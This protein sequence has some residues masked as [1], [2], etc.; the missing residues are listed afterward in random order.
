M[1]AHRIIALGILA[2]VVIGGLVNST[3]LFAADT[4]STPQPCL[5]YHFHKGDSL[6]Y[7]VFS[8]DTVVVYGKPTFVRERTEHISIV[9]DYVDELGNMYLRQKLEKVLS[10]ESAGKDSAI[11]TTSH[12]VGRTAMIIM[13]STGKRSLSRQYDTTRHAMSVGGPFQP[14]LLPP[15]FDSLCHT[16]KNNRGWQLDVL[17]TLAENGYPSPLLKHFYSYIIRGRV[18]TLGV[19][20]TNLQ[21][22]ET[23]QGSILNNAENAQVYSRTVMNSSGSFY[24]SINRRVPITGIIECVNNLTI[25][26]PNK[27]DTS[28]K[29]FTRT[30]FTLVYPALPNPVKKHILP[31]PMP[32]RKLKKK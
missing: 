28:A 5:G 8:Y 21:Y 22:A 19:H 15:L 11:R 31:T 13:D 12:W 3:P 9:C 14:M 20:C 7:K 32:N 23:G 2:L 6:V 10:K 25:K 1:T 27:P 17:D 18:D 26:M 4:T 30:V 24:F 16:A 29:S